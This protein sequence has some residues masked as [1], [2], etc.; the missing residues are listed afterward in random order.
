MIFQI[1]KLHLSLL[2]STNYGR[3]KLNL[4]WELLCVKKENNHAN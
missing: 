1:T 4:S 2:P 3:A